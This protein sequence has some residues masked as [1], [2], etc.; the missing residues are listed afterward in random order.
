M[1]K[2]SCLCGAI[3]YE[4]EALTSPIGLCHCHTCQ[5]AHASAYAPTARVTRAGFR[6]TKGADVVAKF[7]STPGEKARWFCPRCGTHLM[8]EWYK[9]DQVILRVGSLDSDISERPAVHIWMEDARAMLE[10]APGLPALPQ[11]R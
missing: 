1:L 6:W 11:G 5:K 10:P 9:Y 2:G 3:A 8:A 4:C 7:E